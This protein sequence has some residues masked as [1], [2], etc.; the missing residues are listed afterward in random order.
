MYMVECSMECFMHKDFISEPCV[1]QSTFGINY[2][3]LDIAL[4]KGIN[5][6]KLTLK[7]LNF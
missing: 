4:L 5:A 2:W 7:V 1:F 3:L 6:A